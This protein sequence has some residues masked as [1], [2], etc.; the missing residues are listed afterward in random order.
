MSEYCNFETEDGKC[1]LTKTKFGALDIRMNIEECANDGCIL[2][3]IEVLLKDNF[4][5]ES[6]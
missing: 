6:I 4:K 2:K 5:F 1:L 3:Q